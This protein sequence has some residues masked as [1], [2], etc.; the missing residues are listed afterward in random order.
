M[1]N[2]GDGLLTHIPPDWR[3]RLPIALEAPLSPDA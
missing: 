2:L 1:E 3:G